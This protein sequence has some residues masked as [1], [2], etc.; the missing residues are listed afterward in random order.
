MSHATHRTA[1]PWTAEDQAE[2]ERLRQEG[3]SLNRIARTMDRSDSVI[4]RNLDG[5]RPPAE[6]S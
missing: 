2:A 3:L 4:R 1:R 5:W 6:P